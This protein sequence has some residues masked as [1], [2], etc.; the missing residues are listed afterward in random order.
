MLRR[1]I[2]RV[3]AATQ[4]PVPGTYPRAPL[5]KG[6]ARPPLRSDQPSSREVTTR[7]KGK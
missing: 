7:F 2:Q 3:L 6:L 4:A 5:T 1:M